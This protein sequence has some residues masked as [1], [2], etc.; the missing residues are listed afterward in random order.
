VGYPARLLAEGEEVVVDTHPHWWY[1]AAPVAASALM[2]AAAVA[3]YAESMPS[4]VGWSV[5]VLLA[6]AIAWLLGRYA[7]WLTTSLVVTTERVVDRRG[8]LGRSGREVALAH[9][10]DISYHQSLWG[11]LIG[12]GDLVIESPARGGME[13]FSALPHPEGIRAEI[14]RAINRGRRGA[15]S[16]E[17]SVAEQLER[18]DALRRRGALSQMEFEK[19]KARL[20]DR[21]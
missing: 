14:Y 4:A 3:V 21:R 10:T 12:V 20:L 16:G 15:G 9:V 13:V 6:V 17:L 1:L 2:V 19:V 7:R 11:R 8:L 18:L 5:L